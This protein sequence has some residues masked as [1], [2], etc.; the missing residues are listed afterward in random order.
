M[1]LS[2]GKKAEWDDASNVGFRTGDDKPDWVGHGHRR[3]C[4]RWSAGISG[5]TPFESMVTDLADSVKWERLP[6]AADG[7]N[8]LLRWAWRVYKVRV[9][10]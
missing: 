3:A 1:G 2:G 10:L 4:G 6:K 5:I 9:V 7:R 8:R